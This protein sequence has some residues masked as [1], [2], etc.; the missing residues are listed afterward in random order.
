MPEKLNDGFKVFAQEETRL[1]RASA[2]LCDFKLMGRKP[3]NTFRLE[4]QMVP[5]FSEDKHI[6]SAAIYFDGASVRALISFDYATPERLD[7]ELNERSL[8]AL[9]VGDFYVTDPW[10]G[11]TDYADIT[12]IELQRFPSPYAG[13]DSRLTYTIYEN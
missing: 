11:I 13:A 3:L 5:V 2:V 1:V 10:S 7:L 6:G 9:C 12:K 8:Y 4:R